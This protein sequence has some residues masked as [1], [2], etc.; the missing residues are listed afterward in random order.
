MHKHSH[1][2]GINATCSATTPSPVQYRVKFRAVFDFDRI[3]F[4]SQPKIHPI[5]R[6]INTGAPVHIN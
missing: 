6:N 4:H 1:Y 3:Q 5:K 2:P